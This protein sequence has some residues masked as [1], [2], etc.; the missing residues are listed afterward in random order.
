MV[1]DPRTCGCEEK[2]STSVLLHACPVCTKQAL[3]F[4][5]IVNDI[6]DGLRYNGYVDN[7]SGKVKCD[8]QSDW[9]RET[10]AVRSPLRALQGSSPLEAREK[11]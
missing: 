8:I 11:G 5:R 10:S 6:P 3:D 4:M 9:L 2:P 7:M 1:K